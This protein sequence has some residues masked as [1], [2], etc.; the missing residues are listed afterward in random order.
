MI[1]KLRKLL[2]TCA[3]VLSAAA[4][5]VFSLP[6]QAQ[7]ASESDLTFTKISDGESY[8]VTGCNSL[9]QGD[10]QIPAT[11]QGK[12]VTVI[13]YSAFYSCRKLTNITAPASVTS[14]ERAAFS[15]C[16]SLTNI[17]I[18]SSV[19]SIGSEAFAGCSNLTVLPSRAV[20]PALVIM[21]FSIAKT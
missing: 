10:L 13:G 12:P 8:S 21:R 14:I 18:P 16:T 5:C 4:L 20:L 15:R 7:A 19:T 17:T 2:W 1:M 3:F 9:A 11:Y 6:Q